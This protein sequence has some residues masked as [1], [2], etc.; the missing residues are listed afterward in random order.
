[1]VQGERYSTRGVD[2]KT[3]KG[4]KNGNGETDYGVLREL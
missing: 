1:V 2:D 4:R 3:I